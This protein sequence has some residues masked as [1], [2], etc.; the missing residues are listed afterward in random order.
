MCVTNAIT[1]NKYAKYM[2]VSKQE[3]DA[4]TFQWNTAMRK[5]KE[6]VQNHPKK[7]EIAQKIIDAR[8]DKK[9]ITFC[10]TIKQAES[11]K[12]GFVVHSGVA[13]K[14]NRITIEEFSKMKTGVINS[15]KALTE[16]LDCPGLSVGIILSTNSSKTK[17]TQERG[18]VIRAEEGKEAEIFTLIIPY[19]V[20]EKW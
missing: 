15:S 6:F 17:K 20:E 16:G 19:T 1:R 4:H 11:I 3:I 10:S 8:S 5:R 7:V 13:K 2:G 12:R 14:K 18:R 9:I